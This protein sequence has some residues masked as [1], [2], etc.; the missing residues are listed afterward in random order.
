MGARFDIDTSELEQL[1][2]RLYRAQ[3]EFGVRSVEKVFVAGARKLRT[4]IRREAPKGPTGNLRKRIRAKTYKRGQRPRGAYAWSAAPHAHLNIRGTQE[5]FH[6]SGKSVG[7]M[8]PNPFVDRGA[9]AGMPEAIAEM[10]K[11]ATE[12]FVQDLKK[13]R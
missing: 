10:D 7:R 11:K 2:R 3:E 9:S 1:G 6:K 12:L 5:R 13:T 8:T 4:P